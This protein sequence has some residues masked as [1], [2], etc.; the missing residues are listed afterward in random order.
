MVIGRLSAEGN[1]K[2]GF[3]GSQVTRERE[4][5]TP[6]SLGDGLKAASTDSLK[7]CATLLGVGLHLYADTPIGRR[8]PAPAP[9]QPPPRQPRPRSRRRRPRSTGAARA[10]AAPPATGNRDG[11]GQSGPSGGDSASFTKF[12]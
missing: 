9:S 10:M 4:S 5:G 1:T 2:M 11:A 8:R 6:L 12:H 3:G 7:K